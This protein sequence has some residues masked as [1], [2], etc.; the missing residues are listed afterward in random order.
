[1]PR[2]QALGLTISIFAVLAFPAFKKIVGVG[3]ELDSML[4]E[5]QS[6]FTDMIR[7]AMARKH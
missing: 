5:G 2:G 6:G 7:G 3:R 4:V 1:M